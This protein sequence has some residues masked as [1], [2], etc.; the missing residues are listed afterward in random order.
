MGGT[1]S[2]VK[3]WVAEV[4]SYADLNA[5]FDNIL[6]NLTPA[7]IDDLSVSNSAMQGQTDPYP[8]SVISL[9]TSLAGEIQRLR[10]QLA[11]ITGNTYWY[12]DTPTTLAA[13]QDIFD[14]GQWVPVTVASLTYVNATQFTVA[15]DK[16]SVFLQGTRIKATVTAGTV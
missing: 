6:N 16:T 1:F 3:T 4:L 14:H 13:L 5:E 10:Y 11:A 15:T 12:E 7:G 2:R 8:G 9:A